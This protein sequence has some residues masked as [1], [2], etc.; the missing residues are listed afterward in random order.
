MEYNKKLP[1][2]LTIKPSEQITT[3]PSII[4]LELGIK[5]E[6]LKRFELV[7]EKYAATN[8]KIY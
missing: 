2:H 8:V 5:T 3:G 1:E 6:H 4:H 7:C